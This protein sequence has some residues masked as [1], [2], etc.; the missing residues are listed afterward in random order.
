MDIGSNVLRPLGSH[1]YKLGEG[2]TYDPFVDTAWWFDIL[3]R[4]LIEHRFTS[5]ETIA[6]DLPLVASALARVDGERQ[7]L[8]TEKGLYVREVATGR[9]TLHREIEANDTTTRCN[10]ARPHASGAWWISTMGREGEEG[11][12]SIYWYRRGEVRKLFGALSVPN[13]ICFSPSGDRAYFSDTPAGQIFTVQI[14]VAT[15]L[16]TGDPIAFGPSNLRGDPDGAVTDAE[17]RLVVARFGGGCVSVLDP[18]GRHLRDVDL[19]TAQATCPAFVGKDASKLL[20]TTSAE[21][22]D[23]E[24]LR[25]EPEAG[26]TFIGEV[27][28]V[29]R[30]NPE[31]SIA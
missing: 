14:D 8:M 24:R 9:L 4:K 10:D 3:G 30:F 6:H 16:P 25:S 18:D 22:Y 13:A 11:K 15:G 31:V 5:G 27:G 26:A 17:G 21:G 7:L 29:G 23:L 2:P 12:G 20:V 1:R 19:P 28:L